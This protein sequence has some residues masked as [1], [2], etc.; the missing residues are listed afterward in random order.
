MSEKANNVNT[1]EG[2]KPQAQSERKPMDKSV[3][4]KT[5]Q[6]EN[7]TSGG[8]PLP[9]D[10][11]RRIVL[12]WIGYAVAMLA[13]SAASYACIWYAT[14]TTGSPLSL[15]FLYVLAFLPTGLLSPFGGVLADRLNRKTII[16]ASDSIMA[17]ASFALAAWIFIVGPGFVPVALYCAAYGL[18]SGFRTPAYNA[19]M[20]LLVPARH[21]VRINSMD[22]L[23]GSISLIAGP[24]LGIL[25]Y[26][27]FGLQSTLLLGSI[28]A[29]IAAATMLL[30]V[31][32]SDQGTHEHAGAWASLREGASALAKQRG[33][34]V[35]TIGVSL[36]MLAYGP[37]DSL[38]PLMVHNHFGGDGLAASL[39]AAVMGI[40]LFVGSVG[41]MIV[42]PQKKLARIIVVAAYIVGGGAVASGMI[43]STGFWVFVVCIGV[44]A[45]ACAWFNAPLMTLLQKGVPEEKLGRVMGLFT[46]MN[47]MAIPAGTAVGGAVA[48]ATGTPLFFVIDGAFL[49][50]LAT[51][52]AL[53]KS[54]RA[55]DAN[56]DE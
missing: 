27:S 11:F 20:P 52:L 48:E 33:L 47:G 37:I 5:A 1:N 53:S 9:S 17:L 51:F 30:A 45:I 46:A 15:A 38:I 42:N 44:L 26:T 4:Q 25:L 29:A 54:V 35:L 24:A 8:H 40:G 12:I 23:L 19:T 18:V 6:A 49:L 56:S 36:G 31:I 10:W 39:V 2:A 3:A 14:E 16:V 7:L 28:G 55:L 32:P 50:V 41:L 34:L 13:G 43:P 22:T 21:L